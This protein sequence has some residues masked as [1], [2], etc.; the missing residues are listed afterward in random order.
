MLELLQKLDAVLARE[1]AA[2]QTKAA[3]VTLARLGAETAV[4]RCAWLYFSAAPGGDRP[5]GQ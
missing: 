5:I 1:Q 3:E 4:L 2:A